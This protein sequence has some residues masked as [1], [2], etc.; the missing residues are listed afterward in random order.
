VNIYILSLC[1]W[2]IRMQKRCY[3]KNPPS[4]KSLCTFAANLY[5]DQNAFIKNTAKADFFPSWRKK[6]KKR[7]DSAR[8]SSLKKFFLLSTSCF[9]GIRE[10]WFTRWR[11][12]AES[13]VAGCWLG[14]CYWDGMPLFWSRISKYLATGP[15]RVWT[16]LMDTSIHLLD[17]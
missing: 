4:I 10:L 2:Y 16:L 6:E 13:W 15:G 14:P 5:A 17:V 7:D 9:P 12:S 11:L 3:I 1:M 8:C